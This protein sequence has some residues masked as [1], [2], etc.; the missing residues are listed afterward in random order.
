[1]RG[2]NYWSNRW[3]K[4]ITMKLD[5]EDYEQKPSDVIPGF[6]ERIKELLPT[7]FSH[8]CSYGYEGGFLQRIDEGTYAGHVIEHIAL[9]MQTLAGMDTGFGRTRESDS[10]GVYNVVFSYVEEEAGKYTARAA[11]DIFLGLAEGVPIDAL[12][13]KLNE[14]I[15][16]LREIREDVRFGPSTGSIIEEAENRGIPHIRLNEH[17]LVQLGYGIYQKTIQATITCKTSMIATDIASDKAL[18]KRLLESMGVPVPKG[19]KIYNEEEIE[20]TID[21]IGYPVAIAA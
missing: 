7:L 3:K 2:A 21:A 17:S 8:T 12:R 4:L 18:S 14:D 11:V 16:K 15:Q 13:I 19:Y 1:M 6:P 10:P 5:I 9:E 20:E